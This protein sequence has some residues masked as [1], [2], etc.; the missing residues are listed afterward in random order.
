MLIAVTLHACG[1]SNQGGGESFEARL[2]VTSGATDEVLQL[3][4]RDGRI[5]G[6]FSLER[7]RDEIDGPHGIVVAPDGRHWYATLSHGEP[8]LWKFERPGDR[9]VGRVGLGTKGAARIGVTPDGSRG[10]IPDYYR[11]GQG[12]PS[13][14]AVVNLSD[15]SIVARPTLC[16]APHDAQVQ[17]SGELVAVACSMS[18]EV[19]VLDVASLGQVDRFFVDTLPGPAGLPRFK[20]LNLVWSPDGATLYVA[21]HAAGEIRAFSIQGE[22]LGV[23]AVGPGPAQIAIADNGR[24]LVTANRNDASVSILRLPELQER[25]RIDIGRPHPH[26]VALGKGGKLAYVT[27]EGDVGSSGGVVAIDL[28][29]M[30]PVWTAEAGAFTLGIVYVDSEGP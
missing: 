11:S 19:V 3:D 5:T 1:S 27:Y 6:S 18:D 21:L 10:F 17:P 7:R 9:L 23:A 13:A 26:G 16:P 4:P 2:Y 24:T 30:E 14:M 22:P 20:P 8:T 29:T 25:A 15:L 12:R 28:E